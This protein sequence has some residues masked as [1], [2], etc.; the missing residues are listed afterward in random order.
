[1]ATKNE[2][3]VSKL[4][5][6]QA[7][8]AKEIENLVVNIGKN[9]HH[10]HTL[11]RRNAKKECLDDLWQQFSDGH[12][13]LTK[14]IAEDHPYLN[15]NLFQST[16]ATLQTG[17]MKLET[18]KMPDSESNREPPSTETTGNNEGATAT[19]SLTG[20][21]PKTTFTTPGCV[22]TAIA[23]DAPGLYQAGNQGPAHGLVQMH[24]T[25][26]TAPD[27]TGFH[28]AG[29]TNPRRHAIEEAQTM[30]HQ[31]A[32]GPHQ[33]SPTGTWTFVPAQPKNQ[34]T[35]LH[36]PVISAPWSSTTSGKQQ[37][38]VNQPLAAEASQSLHSSDTPGLHQPGR[39]FLQ[40]QAVGGQQTTSV[41]Q[42]PATQPFAAG[43]SQ[44]LH[45][46]VVTGRAFLQPQAVDGP[47]TTTTPYVGLHQRGQLPLQSLALGGP[48]PMLI[49]GNQ[50]ARPQSAGSSN[51][52]LGHSQVYF[53]SP[54]APKLAPIVIPCFNGEWQQWTT[55]IG[56]F[57]T[58]IDANPYLAP[59]QKMQYLLNYTKGEARESIEHI[60]PTNENYTIALDILRRRYNNERKICD[61]YVA[62]ILDLPRMENRSAAGILNIYNVLTMALHGLQRANFQTESWAPMVVACVTRKLDEDSRQ[63]F[64][65]ALTDSRRVPSIT[66][67]LEFLD[68]RYQVLLTDA[69]CRAATKKKSFAVV[70]AAATGTTVRTPNGK[71]YRKCVLCQSEE[72]FVRQCS[73]FLKKKVPERMQFAKTQR[74]CTNCLGTHEGKCSS[75]FSCQHC[76]SLHHTLLHLDSQEKRGPS[77]ARN[78]THNHLASKGGHVLLAT[79]LVKVRNIFG[80]YETLRALIDPGSQDS[81][82]TSAAADAL[83]LQKT[84]TNISVSGIGGTD[85]GKIASQVEINFTSHYPTRQQ[86]STSALVLPKLTS[87][88]PERTIE[89][90]AIPALPKNLLLA[91]PEF[92]ESGKI[93]LLLGAGLFAEIVKE[94]S[95]KFNG[96]QLLLQNTELGWI[97]TGRLMEPS[98]VLYTRCLIT[99]TELDEKM[100]AFWEMEEMP[101][102]PDVRNQLDE[103]FDRTTTRDDNGRYTVRLPKKEDVFGELGASRNTA[104]ASFLNLEKSFTKNPHLAAEYN[105]FLKEYEDLGHMTKVSP[106]SGPESGAYYLPHHAVIKESS[107][108]TKVRVVFNAS[109]KTHTGLSLN[110]LLNPGYKQQQDLHHII[111]RWRKHQYVITADIE[112]MFRQIVVA[113]ED[114]D[115]QRIIWRE[116]PADPI[117]E[118]QLNTVTYGTASATFL[119]VRTMIQLARDEGHHFPLANQVL[120]RD[121]YMDDLLSGDDTI[122]KAVLIQSQITALLQKGGFNIR[123]W[124]SNSKALMD[125]IPE[126]LRES[127]DWQLNPDATIKTLGVVWNPQKD[128]FRIR[129]DL[130]EFAHQKLTKLSLLSNIATIFDP[131]GFLA[132]ISFTCKTWME[133]L[134]KEETDWDQ[135]V[136]N[137]IEEKWNSLRNELPLINEMVVPRWLQYSN[138]ALT[139]IH[140]FCDASEKGYAAVIYSRIVDDNGKVHINLLTSKTKVAPLKNQ[141]TLPRMELAGAVLLAQLVQDSLQALELIDP[142]IY[143]WCDSQIAL[144]WIA[145][146]PSTWTTFVANR[147]ASIQQM[148][149]TTQWR[150]VNT[151]DNPADVASRGCSPS[152]LQHHTLWWTGPLWLQDAP[153]NWPSAPKST[154][155][156]LEMKP[157]KSTTLL[158][159]TSPTDNALLNRFSSFNRLIRVT[160]WILRFKNNSSRKTTLTGGLQPEELHDARSKI[161][162]QLQL[163][164][165]GEEIIALQRKQPLPRRSLINGLAPFLGDDGLL[166]LGGRLRHADLPLDAKHP[167]LLPRHH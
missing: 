160:A 121:F 116:S 69:N 80:Q 112:K 157:T 104:I 85:A 137:D 8:L 163:Q 90:A 126:D 120:L 7:Y 46:S 4:I 73:S 28:Q 43:E 22:T 79:A 72:H 20:T 49:P 78:I 56:L 23:P 118:Y 158:A 162:Q 108:T 19:S 6:C 132:P 142:E 29:H 114:R 64:E 58:M 151:K 67:L 12:N 36:Q 101:P 105:K 17:L 21:I 75:R 24:V 3:E 141:M 33:P 93:D 139:Q 125:L 140:G 153:A 92:A 61:A 98:T 148:T 149:T 16:W 59:I 45:S 86:F 51:N 131:L 66:Q 42:I 70:T 41:Q 88:L 83:S 10:T 1:M 55:F 143:L 138:G 5:N 82:I 47:Q 152:A 2:G 11:S 48:Q 129:L 14:E 133:Q 52:S 146:P 102:Q 81:F 18:W 13:K 62:K 136:S 60:M 109:A 103:F 77:A 113:P 15:D 76:Q 53:P 44:S 32:R 147:V 167:A 150:Y 97:L 155:T 127:G 123:K 26:S 57:E 115:L 166:R 74:L 54:A 135:Q 117:S 68:R 99:M 34:Y 35:G 145:N 63:K 91:D 50:Q 161:L 165:F 30:I 159:A 84:R 130:N 96:K 111:L 144:A 100:K 87:H 110:S 156:D 40:P 38:P 89:P 9:A 128:E 119:A 27:T 95:H 134:W 71:P 37:M 106:F 107:T 25:H 124:T 39:A 94:G 164:E 122:E 154:C 31:D 65:E